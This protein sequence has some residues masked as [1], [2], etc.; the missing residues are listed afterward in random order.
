MELESPQCFDS[1][2]CGDLIEVKKSQ[3]TAENELRGRLLILGE[4]TIVLGG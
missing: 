4:R 2:R 1:N 3:P